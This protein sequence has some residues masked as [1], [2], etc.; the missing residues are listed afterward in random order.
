MEVSPGR[1]VRSNYEPKT[2]KQDVQNSIVLF[3]IPESQDDQ[4]VN[5]VSC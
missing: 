1:A 5:V 3:W 4:P 2:Q